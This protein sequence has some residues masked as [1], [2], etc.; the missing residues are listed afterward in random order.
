MSYTLSSYDLL[1]K[2]G[3]QAGHSPNSN[4]AIQGVFDMPAR[5]GETFHSW[6]DENGIEPFVASGD[7]FFG[8]RDINFMGSITGG[9]LALNTNLKLLYDDIEAVTGLTTLSTPYGDYSGMV[10]KV[11]PEYLPG[12]CAVALQFREPVVDLSG[13]TL[14]AS[15]VSDYTFDL[16]PMLSFG[17]YPSGSKELHALPEFKEMQFTKYG[18]EG[19]QITKRKN[20]MLE[21]EGV[22]IGSS[23]SDFQ[24]KIKALYKLFSNPGLRTVK[25]NSEVSV[26]CFA[27]KGF[28]VDNVFIYNSGMAGKFK[29]N[30]TVISVTNL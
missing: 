14:P 12:G 9:N 5:I 23:L 25:L 27:E 13:G 15:G 8:G 16:I 28:T 7:I 18:S 10:R 19:Y 3:I 30:L 20:R 22:I 4:L 6:G 11:D 17:V 21:F 1:T 2:Y 29:I 26:S 24:N